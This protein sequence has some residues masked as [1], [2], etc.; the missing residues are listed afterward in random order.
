MKTRIPFTR[1]AKKVASRYTND[2][3]KIKAFCDCRMEVL[4]QKY[5]DENGP[6]RTHG[7][8]NE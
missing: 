6:S 1:H 5:P 8:G 3:G 4:M 7:Y 2:S